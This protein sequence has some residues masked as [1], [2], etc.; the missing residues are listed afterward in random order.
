MNIGNYLQSFIN[1]NHHNEVTRGMQFEQDTVTVSLFIR[2]L[3]VNNWARKHVV[4]TS[5]YS[6]N[7][8]P[9]PGEQTLDANR[10]RC[11]QT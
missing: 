7:T 11:A 3:A 2:E 5:G 6:T 10:N 4:S 9:T 1:K 8:R